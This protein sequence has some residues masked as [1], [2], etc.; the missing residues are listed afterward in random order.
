MLK[1]NYANKQDQCFEGHSA[2][3]EGKHSHC[4]LTGLEPGLRLTFQLCLELRLLWLFN[5]F[6]RTHSPVMQPELG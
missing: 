2:Q 5:Q 6:S 3:P 4:G 1:Y